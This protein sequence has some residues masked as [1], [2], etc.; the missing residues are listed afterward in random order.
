M[1]YAFGKGEMR[2]ISFKGAIGAAQTLPW[3]DHAFMP[4][5]ASERAGEGT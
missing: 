1:D 4:L 3:G 2:I 5:R